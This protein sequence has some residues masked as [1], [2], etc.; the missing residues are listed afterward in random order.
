MKATQRIAIPPGTHALRIERVP[1]YTKT[2]KAT[3]DTIHM[4]DYDI[5]VVGMWRVW[6]NAN[7]DF[8]AGTYLALHDNGC[9]ERVTINPDGTEDTF[10]VKPEDT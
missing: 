9:I 4:V 7:I 3:V 1:S 2:V 8:T 6:I 5:T 10:L